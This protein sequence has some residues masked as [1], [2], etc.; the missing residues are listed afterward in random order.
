[1]DPSETKNLILEVL[2]RGY[3]MSLGTLSVCHPE[4]AGEGSWLQGSS[5]NHLRMTLRTLAQDALVTV[6]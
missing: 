2:S 3:L 4:R 1:M 5:A 6:R